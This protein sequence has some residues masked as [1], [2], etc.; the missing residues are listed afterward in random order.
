M[1]TEYFLYN[2]VT[3]ETVTLSDYGDADGIAELQKQG[4]YML[5]PDEYGDDAYAYPAI[6]KSP[7]IVWDQSEDRKTNGD[8]TMMTRKLD[9]ESNSGDD[10]SSSDNL[11]NGNG[12]E[13]SNGD[14]ESAGDS[15]NTG[16]TENPVYLT[17]NDGRRN[18][19]GMG[20]Y[21]LGGTH[22]IGF[23]TYATGMRE[24]PDAFIPLWMSDGKDI[25]S[26]LP[27]FPSPGGAREGEVTGMFQ[28]DDKAYVVFKDERERFYKQAFK[29]NKTDGIATGGEQ[30]A[31]KSWI[32]KNEISHSVDLN[33]D[34]LFGNPRKKTDDL[35]EAE[36]NNDSFKNK[37]EGKKLLKK[38]QRGGFVIY[39]RHATTETD[40][41]DQADPNL[42]LDDPSTQRMLS[43]QG[44]QEA[45]D[46]GKGFKAN[47]IIVG[48]I[49]SSEYQRAK[50]TADL[51]FG[52]YQEN[53]NLNFLP[54][55][56]Y[57]DEQLDTY[58]DRIAPMISKKPKGSRKN[59]VIIGHDDPFEGTTNIYPDPQGTSYIIK[60]NDDSYDIIAKLQPSD[61]S[62]GADI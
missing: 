51:A 20:L 21:Y 35:S 18:S 57:T 11:G 43:A 37:F 59:T 10:G 55:E 30:K 13:D 2:S 34:Q 12:V 25:N 15:N 26:D 29:M 47:D 56:D 27:S 53:P 54:F 8:W 33:G 48:N 40:Y 45:T 9:S 52:K 36:F 58:H 32:Y 24:T 1:A 61:W 38:L 22:E 28:S 46:I 6:Y 50:D 3:K 39:M 19:M 17:Y 60:P 44:I 14:K 31:K 23:G 7:G 41:A 49:F 5:A 42:N 4:F 62:F 16:N